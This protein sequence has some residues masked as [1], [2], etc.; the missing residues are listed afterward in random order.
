MKDNDP[1][2]FL[3]IARR[4]EA[5]TAESDFATGLARVWHE[6]AAIAGLP[7]AYLNV[8]NLIE[9]GA[10]TNFENGRIGP[11]EFAYRREESAAFRRMAAYPLLGEATGVFEQPDSVEYDADTVTKF[12]GR[13]GFFRKDLANSLVVQS[14]VPVQFIDGDCT[15]SLPRN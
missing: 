8:A 3:E 2:A 4:T 7:M 11:E 6:R 13:Y 5:L 12:I 15:S 14:P 1:E 9:R 10:T